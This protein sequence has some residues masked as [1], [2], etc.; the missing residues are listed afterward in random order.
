MQWDDDDFDVLADGIV[1]GRILRVHAAPAGMP[2]MWTLDGYA[3]MPYLPPG[4]VPCDAWGKSKPRACRGFRV[5]SVI[6]L[7]G[8]L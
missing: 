5:M 2:W 4:S 3:A 8:E 6:H 7:E 1:V